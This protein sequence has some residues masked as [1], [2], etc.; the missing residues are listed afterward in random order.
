ME[1]ASSIL[2]KV[3]ISALFVFVV[4]SMFSISVTQ[5]AGGIG[6]IAWLWRTQLNREW[7]RQSWPL[8]IPIGLYVLACLIAVAD[9]YDEVIHM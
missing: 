8:A 7:S 6:G 5:I 2:D 9:A 3:V 1:Q 4:F